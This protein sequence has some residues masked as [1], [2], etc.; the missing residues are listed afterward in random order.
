MT[1]IT[2]GILS[3]PEVRF[4]LDTPYY[5]NGASVEGEQTAVAQA[6]WHPMARESAPAYNVHPSSGGDGGGCVSA[7]T[8][9]P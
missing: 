5:I 2:V 1:T 6:G 9:L 7:F 4:R 8:T 3:A